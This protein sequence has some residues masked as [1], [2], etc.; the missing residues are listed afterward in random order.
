MD[1]PKGGSFKQ[2][3]PTNTN[4]RKTKTAGGFW[5]RLDLPAL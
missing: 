2:L 1:A 3:D 5:H 4:A